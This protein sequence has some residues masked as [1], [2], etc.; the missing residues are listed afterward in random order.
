MKIETHQ[1]PMGYQAIDSDSFDG[2]PD[3]HCAVG[4]GSTPEEA[5]DD[6]REQ[7]E[8]PIVVGDQ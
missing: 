5:I 8:W 7:F 4:E 1:T 6:L 3:A 2:A